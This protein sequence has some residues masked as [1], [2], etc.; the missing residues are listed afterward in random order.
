[1]ANDPYYHDTP[2]LRFEW[3]GWETDTYR[4]SQNGWDVSVQK[5]LYRKELNIAIKHQI[6]GFLGLSGRIDFDYWEYREKLFRGEYG[7][8]KFDGRALR[9]NMSQDDVLHRYVEIPSISEISFSPVD[10]TPR[11]YEMKTITIE[12]IKREIP[13]HTIENCRDNIYLEKASMADILKTALSKQV[14]MQKEI[15]ERMYMDELRAKSKIQ[16]KLRLI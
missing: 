16:A 1:M 4:L 14:P 7:G 2:V 8:S 6:S 15:R 11:A 10:V 5:D 13:F 9:M 3:A 12:D